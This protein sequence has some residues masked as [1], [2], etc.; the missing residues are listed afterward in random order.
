VITTNLQP[1]NVIA[2][3]KCEVGNEQLNT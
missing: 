1:H 2:T 3:E